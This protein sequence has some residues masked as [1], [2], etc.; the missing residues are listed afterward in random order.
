GNSLNFEIANYSATTGAME[1]YVNIATLSHTTDN[2]F[3]MFYGNASVVT[4]Q[5]TLSF[6]ATANYKSVYHLIDGT[7]LGAKDSTGTF[8]GT[9]TTANATT[10]ALDGGMNVN[11]G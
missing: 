8:N 5:Q 7:T 10:G 4:S 1:A 3:W 2:S 11:G 9:I 6:W